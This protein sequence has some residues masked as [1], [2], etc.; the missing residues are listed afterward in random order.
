[1]GRQSL[2]R[3]PRSGAIAFAIGVHIFDL[4]ALLSVEWALESLRSAVETANNDLHHY[5]DLDIL[6]PVIANWRR[7]NRV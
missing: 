2:R 5:K 3:L 1:M 7:K 6:S 4:S